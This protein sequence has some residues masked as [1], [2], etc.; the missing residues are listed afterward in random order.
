ME[1]QKS[2]WLTFKAVCLHFLGNVK[3]EKYKE[4]FEDFLNANQTTGCNMSLKIQFLHSHLD[5][6]PPNLGAASK[7]HRKGSTRA[8][9]AQRKD[10]QGSCH[11][12]CYLTIVGTLLKRHLLPVK[13]EGVTE[14][15][16]K[17]ETIIAN[18]Q[19]QLHNSIFS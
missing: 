1:T 6:F 11:R 12:T 19:T 18:H 10:M 4:L 15:S 8:F 2:A 17:H 7:E 14:K 3:A 5:F 16:F 9:S 13:N